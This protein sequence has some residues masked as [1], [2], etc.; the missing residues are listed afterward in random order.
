MWIEGMGDVLFLDFN[1][2]FNSVS[3]KNFIW[4]L[5]KYKP[6]EWTVKW[7]ESLDVC[8]VEKW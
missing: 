8:Q 2:S 3:I 1:K 5:E 7:P 6:D 4:K